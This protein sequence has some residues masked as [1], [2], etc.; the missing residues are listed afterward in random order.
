MD[1]QASHKSRKNLVKLLE[2]LQS[3]EDQSFFC[4]LSGVTFVFSKL[5]TK[6]SQVASF[7]H[8][9]VNTKPKSPCQE[10]LPPV[11]AVILS[12]KHSLSKIRKKHLNYGMSELCILTLCICYP[13]CSRR[14]RSHPPA[15]G[16]HLD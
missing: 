1:W 3:V 15:N 10:C 5:F 8:Y 13:P 11:L 14:Q 12:F 2:V 7:K 4:S 9:L 16:T 6:E